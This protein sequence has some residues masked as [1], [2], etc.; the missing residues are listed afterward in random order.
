[1]VTANKALVAAHADEL[2]EAADR[3]GVGPAREGA[4]GAAHHPP[5]GGAG[6]AGPHPRPALTLRTATPVNLLANLITY[7][8][9]ASQRGSNN[10]HSHE[11]QAEPQ[12]R[13]DAFLQ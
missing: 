2:A 10:S 3:A 13:W 6:P 11:A 12:C 1:M 5:G 8:R 7:C 4:R 9:K